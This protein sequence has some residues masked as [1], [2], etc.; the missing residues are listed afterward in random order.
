MP[1]RPLAV[2]SALLRVTLRVVTGGAMLGSG[3]AGARAQLDWPKSLS[4]FCSLPKVW[5]LYHSSSITWELVRDTVSHSSPL[6]NPSC[7]LTGSPD[8][9]FVGTIMSAPMDEQTAYILKIQHPHRSRGRMHPGAGGVGRQ[10]RVG[11]LSP[12][13]LDGTQRG[14][15]R[16]EGLRWEEF[17]DLPRGVQL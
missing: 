9:H 15:Q 4:S 13:Y 14:G 16:P 11:S 17:P 1:Q 3:G 6:L 2:G 8:T 12:L 7:M 10:L 5:P